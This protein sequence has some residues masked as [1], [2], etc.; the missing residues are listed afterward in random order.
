MKN[1][2][3]LNQSPL[4]CWAWFEN[5]S[6]SAWGVLLSSSSTWNTSDSGLGHRRRGQERSGKVVLVA[7]TWL[8]AERCLLLWV[9]GVSHW[10]LLWWLRSSAG[11]RTDFGAD[12]CWAPSWP[13]AL[14]LYSCGFCSGFNSSEELLQWTRRCEGEGELT[15]GHTCSMTFC[16]MSSGIQSAVCTWKRTSAFVFTVRWKFWSGTQKDQNHLEQ[17]HLYWRAVLQD[18]CSC[19]TWQSAALSPHRPEGMKH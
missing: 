3:I 11:S 4:F 5:G 19:C 13:A 14:R 10:P 7:G 15:W 8:L 1:K 9:Q 2:Y 6:S 16:R 17:N 18:H 12:F